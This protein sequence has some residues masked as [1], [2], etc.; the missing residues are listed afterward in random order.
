MEER[1]QIAPTAAGVT[2]QAGD[3]EHDSDPDET[4]VE[5]TAKRRERYRPYQASW[6]GVMPFLVLSFD[7]GARCFR[8]V[9][10]REGCFVYWLSQVR[11]TL[12]HGVP[13][14]RQGQCIHARMQ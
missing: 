12:L 7:L 13:A 2:E 6:M 14:E 5:G 9:P 4:V 8:R 3:D 11:K 10:V 1:V